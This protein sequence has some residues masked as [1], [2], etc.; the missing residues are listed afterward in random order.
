M[1]K[2]NL[3][4][5]AALTLAL[6]LL[7]SGCAGNAPDGGASKGGA[8]SDAANAVAE[9]AKVSANA[10]TVKSAKELYD[11][12]APGAEIVIAP[13]YY[14]LSEFIQ[15]QWESAP[16][17]WDDAHPYVDL[18][19][20]YD[21]AEAVIKGVDNLTITGQ[22]ADVTETELVIEPRYADVFRFENCSNLKVSNLTL[23]HTDTGECA[24]NVITLSACENVELRNDDL[25]GCGVIALECD[26]GTGDV[27]AYACTF[28]DCSYAPLCIYSGVGTFEFYDCALINCEYG[29][30]YDN[31]GRSSVA[32]Y[33]CNF[34]EQ[35]TNYWAF[36]DGVETEDCE[37]SEITEYPDY[38]EEYEV[39]TEITFQP[40]TMSATPF[41]ADSYADTLWTG[42]QILNPD[43]GEPMD[44]PSG[45][46]V[47]DIALS[48]RSDGT[49]VINN[50][51][52][53]R[54]VP[55][56]WEADPQNPAQLSLL[57]RESGAFS[58]TFYL[59]DGDEDGYPRVWL[60]V[61]TP[62]AVVWMY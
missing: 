41:D 26:E 52:A 56:L 19:D 37:W 6:A 13:G 34:G 42:Y 55:F 38:E 27:S 24:G 54:K 15:E 25:Y 50:Y 30:Y 12:I 8:A 23:G 57:T 17:E 11:A 60:S 59:Q 53:N 49:G 39:N 33:R 62:E 29:G 43:S 46:D 28:R 18:E 14:N 2:K 10:V 48:L 1:K 36:A 21:G 51:Y 7:M 22:S 45:G 5:A 31:A 4:G 32:F 35:E 44:A 61:R 9:A 16:D 58:L 47:S 3:V 40:E 20:C